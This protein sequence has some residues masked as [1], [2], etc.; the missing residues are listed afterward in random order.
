VADRKEKGSEV[1]GCTNSMNLI[2][3]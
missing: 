1:N 2:C 3:C